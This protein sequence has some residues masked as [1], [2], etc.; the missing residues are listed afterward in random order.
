MSGFQA[1]MVDDSTT[2][3]PHTGFQAPEV[4]SGYD[5]MTPGPR[6]ITETSFHSLPSD[7]RPGG[8]VWDYGL[9]PQAGR[10]SGAPTRIGT[11]MNE[12]ER[13]AAPI[14]TPYARDAVEGTGWLGRNIGAPAID[15]LNYLGRKGAAVGAGG[16]AALSEVASAGNPQLARDVNA[17]LTVLPVAQAHM[18]PV[19]GPSVTSGPSGPKFGEGPRF[20]TTPPA[21]PQLPAPM[22]SPPVSFAPTPLGDVTKAVVQATPPSWRPVAPGEGHVPGREYRANQTT[23]QYEVNEGGPTS[24]PLPIVPKPPPLPPATVPPEPKWELPI[25]NA[26]DAMRI[27]NPQIAK[28]EASDFK[29]APQF[30]HDWLDTLKDETT[31]T[32]FGKAITPE[33]TPVAKLV[34][35]LKLGANDPLENIKSIQETEQ[36]IRRAMSDQS[37]PGGDDNQ[38]RQMRQILQDF[39]E[40]YSNVDPEHYT[41]SAEGIQS[42][43]DSVK[44]Y[45]A[46]SRLRDVQDIIDGT[47]GNPNRA[48]LIAS[49]TNAFLNDKQNI[50]GW[51]D[52]EIAAVRK[53]A[54]GGILPELVRTY[55]SRLLGIGAGA[56]GGIPAMALAVPAQVG[57]SYMF[58]NAAE[59]ARLSA[60]QRAMEVLGKGVPQPGTVPAPRV[61]PTPPQTAITAARY[62]PLV[63]LLGETQ[64][65]P[66][67]Q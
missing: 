6:K 15:A 64:D 45:A 24:G 13:D 19:G 46:V 63:G 1:P 43:K 3:D 49:R 39:R 7:A 8:G 14:L 67:N 20:T 52:D 47:E 58:R 59:N 62:A 28:A 4:R 18:P 10:V 57:V 41:G 37:K 66:R 60:L 17:G 61:G 31:T 30:T 16:L 53:A 35:E 23:G 25:K 11:A 56:A 22:S 5:D 33:P 51:S 2:N 21:V 9:M 29:L 50:K 36:K 44:S 54:E 48:N 12:A 55:G 27:Y 38:V 42:Y 26:D 40:R 34:S 32:P 65:Q